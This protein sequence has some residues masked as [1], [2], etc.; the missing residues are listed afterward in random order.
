MNEQNNEPE[1]KK[2]KSLFYYIIKKIRISHII[3]LIVLLAANTYAWFIYVN[4]VS[5]SL[6]VHIR[7]WNIDFEDGNS[8]VTDYVNVFVD[9]V[10]PG[11]T[12][13]TK[14]ITAHNYSEVAADVSFKILE[15]NIMGESYITVEGRQEKGQTVQST[16]LTSDQLIEKFGNDYPFSIDFS[17][18]STQMSPENGVST[19][20][21]SISW[22]YESGD[23]ET[24]T[25]WGTRAYTFKNNNPSLPCIQMT[26]KI[27]ITQSET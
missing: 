9:D 16:D 1:K 12:T 14:D 15:A 27:Y 18:D 25:L 23:D 6:D 2:K 22:P 21:I 24:D 4:T 7:S 11:M 17:I 3:I 13:Y 8:P 5:N 19:Y 10:Y 26:V 20:S